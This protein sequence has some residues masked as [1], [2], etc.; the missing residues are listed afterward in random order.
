MQQNWQPTNPVERRFM[1]AHSDWMR[2]AK[3]HTARLMIWYTDEA[4]SP[5]VR[6]FSG[7]G[8]H[9]VRGSNDA[10]GVRDRNALRTG[11]GRR[12][13][14]LLRQPPRC[15]RR[16]GNPYRLAAAVFRRR[17]SGPLPAHRGHQ[18]DR[19]SRMCSRHWYSCSRRPG[20]MTNPHG[21]GGWMAC[22]RPSPRRRNWVSACASSCRA[23]LSSRSRRWFSI[24]RIWSAS[25]T[26]SI[27]WR[28]PRELLAE[29]GER[30]SSGEFRRLFVTMSETVKG[31][32]PARLEALRAAAL[33]VAGR[34][35]VRPVRHRASDCWR[36][37]S[38]MARP[39][40]CRRCISASSGKRHACG[41]RRTSG[42]LEA[43][44]QRIV[45]R[46][47]RASD[48]QDHAR[49]AYCYERR[50][51]RRPPRRMR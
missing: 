12:A 47:E 15:I 50:P 45:R 36:R 7:S 25:C 27:R 24:I 2:F 32:N 5:L 34:E 9:V 29:S 4:D 1:D 3:D 31:G 23:R 28:A 35:V 46:G 6:L 19:T 42:R 51:R 39:R 48:G 21:C 49:A 18:P 17:R 30:G 38:E 40:A 26:A 33:E 10:H 14:C 13:D 8:G 22:C 11:V 16:S 20:R 44:R 37:I 41:E 43:R